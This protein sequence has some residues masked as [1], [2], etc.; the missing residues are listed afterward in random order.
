MSIKIEKQYR[1]E[2]SEILKKLSS[3][4]KRKTVNEIA[5]LFEGTIILIKHSERC[6]DHAINIAEN[7][8]YVKQSDFFFSKRSKLVNE[9]K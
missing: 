1:K 4:L 9:K 6:I 7:F 5:G 2:Y 3:I 8:V